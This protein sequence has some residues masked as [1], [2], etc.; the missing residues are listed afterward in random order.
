MVVGSSPTR[1]TSVYVPQRPE[2]GL[3]RFYKFPKVSTKVDG[4]P[5]YRPVFRHGTRGMSASRLGLRYE[6]LLFFAAPLSLIA[7][8]VLFIAVAT[9]SQQERLQ[10]RCAGEAATVLEA[11]KTELDA[12]W[13]RQIDQIVTRQGPDYQYVL[14]V[15]SAWIFGL[16]VG[17]SCYRIMEVKTDEELYTS[18]QVLIDQLRKTASTSV[19]MP[20]K[21][22]GVEIPERA[23]ISVFGTL[24]NMDLMV[25]TQ[26][27]QLALAPLLLLWLGSLYN[28][29]YRETMINGG[30]AKITELFPHLIN[31]Y[32][33]GKVIPPRKKSWIQYYAPPVVCALYA[34]TRV[35]LLG[36]FIGPPVVFYVASLYFLHPVDYV[37]FFWVLGGLV[38]ISGLTNF[39]VEFFPWHVLKIFPKS[40]G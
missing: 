29:R 9:D 39:F 20:V 27:L 19:V 14:A 1:P 11:K 16:H 26:A 12:E 21:F 10:Y 36:V 31:I 28:T 22:Y 5:V 7:L 15:R 33:V 3:G 37:V 2:L 30:A 4:L 24:I 35:V 8:L 6:R 40:L 23:S 38:S 34:I 32:P 17:S 18:P 13:G 25:L